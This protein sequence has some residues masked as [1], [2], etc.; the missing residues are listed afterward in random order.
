MNVPYSQS[1]RR[2]TSHNYNTPRYH[3]PGSPKIDLLPADSRASDSQ[4]MPGGYCLSGVQLHMWCLYPKQGNDVPTGPVQLR[5]TQYHLCAVWKSKAKAHPIAQQKAAKEG[6]VS[7][8]I[9]YQNSWHLGSYQGHALT[10]YAKACVLHA[11]C[12][13]F[14]KILVMLMWAALTAD[15]HQRTAVYAC[16][17]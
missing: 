4:D 6:L 9:L 10:C 11:H 13:L 3:G 8:H 5:Q 16:V 14:G 15:L 7:C 1:M 2:S 17:Y 12:L